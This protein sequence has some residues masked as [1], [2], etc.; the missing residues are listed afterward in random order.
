M[1]YT[2]IEIRKAGIILLKCTILLFIMASNQILTAQKKPSADDWKIGIEAWTFHD[3]TLAETLDKLDSCNV[4]YLG[5]HPNQEIGNGIE[6]NMDYDKMNVFSCQKV[7]DMLKSK[8]IKMFSYGVITPETDSGWIQLF[9]FAKIMGIKTI[10]AEPTKEQIPFVSKLADEYKIDV[11]IHNHP[12]PTRYWNPDI[13][14]DALKGASPRIGACA[15]IGH[16]VR[17]G[18]DPVECIKKLKGHIIE[19]H[20]KDLNEKG[21]DD[22]HDVP[23]GTGVSNIAGV[24]SEMKRQGFKG[25]VSVEYEY[26]WDNS[27]P[28]VISSIKFFKR[29]T[30]TLFKN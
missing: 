15:D 24:M 18:L 5:G 25:I 26:H 3:F 13:L 17:S 10:L 30:K 22:A 21:L 11:A 28:E 20:M 6:G 14:L 1:N 12:K 29:E 4:K 9:S 23:W 7:L 27:V 16:W 19:F 8:G 2:K